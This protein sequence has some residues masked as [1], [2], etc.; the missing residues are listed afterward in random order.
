VLA[1]IG[2]IAQR[3]TDEPVLIVSHGIA[4]ATVIR[5][6]RGLRLEDIFQHVP[7]NAQTYRMQCSPAQSIH[8]KEIFADRPATLLMPAN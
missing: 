1:A 5:Q 4:L 3:H 6:S 2:E 7:E 8:F